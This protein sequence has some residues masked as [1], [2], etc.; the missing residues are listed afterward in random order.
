MDCVEICPVIF[1]ER[2]FIDAIL[3]YDTETVAYLLELGF[4]CNHTHILEIIRQ[5]HINMLK[6][7]IDHGYILYEKDIKTV[8]VVSNIYMIEY[9]VSLNKVPLTMSI[10]SYAQ[11]LP[12]MKLLCANG[13]RFDYRLI[14]QMRMLADTNRNYNGIAEYLE[15][16][17]EF[18]T[19][20]KSS[21]KLR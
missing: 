19:M 20:Q 14:D 13:L 21:R 1:N 17:E 12:A 15:Q 5:S 2:M 4:V 10:G 3:N 11:S 18:M 6:L 8:L 16:V 7:F 9:V